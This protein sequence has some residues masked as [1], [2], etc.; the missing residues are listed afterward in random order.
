MT[1]EDQHAAHKILGV[2]LGRCLILLYTDDGVL[3]SQ[4]PE[5][6]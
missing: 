1:V 2:L 6:F 5:W 3:G 4:D